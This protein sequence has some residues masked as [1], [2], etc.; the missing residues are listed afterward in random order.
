MLSLSALP[1]EKRPRERLLAKGVETLGLE[2][3]L[4]LIV[5][6]GS[7]GEDVLSLSAKIAQLLKRGEVSVHG[8]AQLPGIG[9]AKATEIVAALH[10]AQALARE[11]LA[12]SLNHPSQVFEACQDLL[13]KPQEHL[14]VFFTTAR[15]KQIT[16]ETVSIGT[17]TS[18]LVHPR[19]VFRPAI[20]HNAAHIVLAHNH[21][22]GEPQPSSADLEVT[23]RVA[24]AGRQLCIELVDHVICASGG[25]TS[26]KTAHPELFL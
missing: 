25:Y 23:L 14:V 21:P 11:R 17:A 1:L 18:S 26:L 3:L 10:L 6:T 15:G 9:M 2:Q 13:E 8:L 4:A 16:R 24:E 7:S 12:S 19:E 20:L 5:R 22:S